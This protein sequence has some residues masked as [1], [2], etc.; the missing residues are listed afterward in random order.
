M[1]ALPY[2]TY[3]VDA[4]PKIFSSGV[5]GAMG[6]FGFGQKKEDK[7][8]FYNIYSLV[9]APFRDYVTGNWPENFTKTEFSQWQLRN[10]C[11]FYNTTA[12]L[13]SSTTGFSN[14][15][16][17]EISR[18]DLCHDD[19]I[20]VISENFF[21]VTLF[22]CIEI[23]TGKKGGGNKAE[24]EEIL[25]EIGQALENANENLEQYMGLKEELGTYDLMKHVSKD[26]RYDFLFNFITDKSYSKWDTD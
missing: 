17:D 22:H 3:L 19:S 9:V 1:Y 10:M 13:I 6:W 21:D 15:T 18:L 11:V 2:R 24:L 8:E 7:L 14:D 16:A 12:R 26:D 5:E 20:P 25:G 4:I 23:M